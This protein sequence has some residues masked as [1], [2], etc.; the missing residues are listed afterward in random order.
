MRIVSATLALNRLLLNG[1]LMM[2][3]TSVAIYRETS[4]TTAVK[5]RIRFMR[6]L[7]RNI[8]LLTTKH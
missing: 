8:D 2:A 1:E 6:L 7:Y 3:Q 5:A 4:S